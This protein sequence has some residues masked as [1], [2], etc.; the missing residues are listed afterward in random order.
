MGDLSGNNLDLVCKILAEGEAGSANRAEHITT[1]SQL[2][3]AHLLTETDVTK[4]AASR[5]LDLANL[6]ITPDCS[7]TEGQSRI[8]LKICR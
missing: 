5:T 8:Q 3:Y 2:F 7:L 6:E 4:L 1:I